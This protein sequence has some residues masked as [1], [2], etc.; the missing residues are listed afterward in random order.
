MVPHFVEYTPNIV[1]LALIQFALQVTTA[2][3]VLAKGVDMA[4]QLP[5]LKVVQ[6]VYCIEVSGRRNLTVERE[7]RFQ[8]FVG[9]TERQHSIGPIAS[10]LRI[11]ISQRRHLT[12]TPGC[13]E[14]KSSRETCHLP[15]R[16][17]FV[18]LILIRKAVR[19]IGR[20]GHRSNPGVC[21]SV[22]SLRH[23][24]FG[25]GSF[26]HFLRSRALLW[27][28]RGF[29]HICCS[30]RF[31]RLPRSG[32]L[33]FTAAIWIASRLKKQRRQFLQRNS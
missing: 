24:R 10:H 7:H 2:M 11:G 27:G 19:W 9:R 26:G 20:I 5:N 17:H 29:F 1:W 32:S 33:L 31:H 22:G 8:T 15:Y 3:L 16:R 6:T 18:M 23:C 28:N 21:S 12:E 14:W 4:L 25:Q 30:G 13:W